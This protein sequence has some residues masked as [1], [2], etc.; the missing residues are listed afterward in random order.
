MRS[1]RDIQARRI[2]HVRCRT[3]I[4]ARQTVGWFLCHGHP[5]L[6]QALTK[7]NTGTTDLL[8]ENQDMLTTDFAYTRP[9]EAEYSHHW[10]RNAGAA[11]FAP[12]SL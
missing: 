5:L 6:G 2:P 9:L 7:H 4:R 8:P 12:S 3:S 10:Y 1:I 11:H